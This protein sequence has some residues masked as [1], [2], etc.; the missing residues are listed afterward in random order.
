MALE[1]SYGQI[2]ADWTGYML[3]FCKKQLILTHLNEDGRPDDSMWRVRHARMLA[4]TIAD[5]SPRTEVL[6]PARGDFMKL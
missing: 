4:E 1:E 5:M 3:R 6:I 2:L